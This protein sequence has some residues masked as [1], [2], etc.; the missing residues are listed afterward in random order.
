LGVESIGAIICLGVVVGL[1]FGGGY[2]WAPSRSWAVALGAIFGVAVA[3]VYM[4]AAVAFGNLLPK[5]LEPRQV[6]IHF[7]VLLVVL[8][9]VGAIAAELARRL[10]IWKDT[11][12]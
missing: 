1:G 7:M 12:R 11:L 9:L 5:A 4:L 10:A 3:A 2:S 6:G 8:P